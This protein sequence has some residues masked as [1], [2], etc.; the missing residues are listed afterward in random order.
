V[1]QKSYRRRRAWTMHDEKALGRVIRPKAR[2]FTPWQ[3]I[4]RIVSCRAII[5][6]D[7]YFAKN[8]KRLNFHM[9]KN[10]SIV[11]SLIALSMHW[12]I[13]FA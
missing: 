1:N 11:F 12:R 3:D 2:A 9:Q 5:S 4:S 13:T 6:H 8:A 10:D 7:Q